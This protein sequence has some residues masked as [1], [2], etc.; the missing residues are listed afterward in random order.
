MRAYAPR[1]WKRHCDEAFFLQDI[2][3]NESNPDMR[4]RSTLR[5]APSGRHRE[6]I[7]MLEW[8]WFVRVKPIAIRFLSIIFTLL[9]VA[10]VWSELL[11]AVPGVVVGLIGII[12]NTQGITYGAIEVYICRCSLVS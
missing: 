7:L 8:L 5:K 11:Y 4:F 10:V 1:E 2:I 3:A 6:L 9:S 12:F